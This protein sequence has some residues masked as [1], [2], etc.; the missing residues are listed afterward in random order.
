M[1]ECAAIRWISRLVVMV[2]GTLNGEGVKALNY[3]IWQNSRAAVVNAVFWTSK[4]STNVNPFN[5]KCSK[6]PF[7]EGLSVILV[8]LIIFSF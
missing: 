5:A 1:T 7:F 4:E 8:R 2:C 6:L 3:I